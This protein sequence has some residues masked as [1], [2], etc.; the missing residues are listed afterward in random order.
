[1]AARR[2]VGW[3]PEARRSLGEAVEYIA[4]ESPEAAI[5]FLEGVLAAARSL[6]RLALRGRIV[7]EIGDHALREL[8]VHRYRLMYL[9]MPDS[10]EILAFIHGARDFERWRRED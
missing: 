8:L 10:V 4:R 9:V 1:M 5:G 2:R 6:K 3:T 7:P